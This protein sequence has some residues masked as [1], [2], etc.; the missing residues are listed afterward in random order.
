[1]KPLDKAVVTVAIEEDIKATVG[2]VIR[3]LG[4]TDEMLIQL[5]YREIAWHGTLPYGLLDSWEKDSTT[6]VTDNVIETLSQQEK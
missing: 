2:S 1:M 6:A 5:I 4:L 3:P